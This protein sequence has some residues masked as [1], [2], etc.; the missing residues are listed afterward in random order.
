MKMVYWIYNMAAN[1]SEPLLISMCAACVTGPDSAATD[2]GQVPD[3]V[4]P[5]H[6]EEYPALQF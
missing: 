4:R 6:W 3:H 2:A 5:D 1:L